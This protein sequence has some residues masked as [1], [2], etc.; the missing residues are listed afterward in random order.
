MRR[1][2]Y[3]I[4]FGVL[5]VGAAIWAI[6]L[7]WYAKQKQEPKETEETAE[8]EEPLESAE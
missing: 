3:S 4:M 1:N 5:A 8:T 6:P 7:I 2:M